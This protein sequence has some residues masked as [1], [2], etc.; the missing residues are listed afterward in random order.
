MAHRGIGILPE[1]GF[2]R[3]LSGIDIELTGIDPCFEELGENADGA[4][5]FD[6]WPR[7]EVKAVVKAIPGL[8]K[9]RRH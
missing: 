1:N 6:E 4:L 3:N 5:Y 9:A 2:F 7:A 8:R